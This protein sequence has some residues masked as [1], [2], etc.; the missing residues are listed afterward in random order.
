MQEP[1]SYLPL[2][3]SPLAPNLVLGSFIQILQKEDPVWGLKLRMPE[4]LTFLGPRW[5][6]DPGLKTDCR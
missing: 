2:L 5:V 6:K 1:G 3:P 4:L